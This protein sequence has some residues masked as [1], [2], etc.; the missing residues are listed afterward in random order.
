MTELFADTSYWMAL[1][2]PRDDLH[3]KARNVSR[4]F[5]SAR[6]I[7]SEMVLAELLNGFSDGGPW[8]R[9]GAARAV[10][11]LR[12]NRSVTIVPQTTEQFQ[13]AVK[14][15]AQFKD[16]NWSLTDCGSF[17]IMREQGIR[18]ALTYDVHFVQAGFEALLR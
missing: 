11:S 13:N 18:A 7:T 14:H 8:L 9:V 17:Q 16:K 4:E 1:V 10:A 12:G 3:S 6:V 15:Y 2:N 5:A